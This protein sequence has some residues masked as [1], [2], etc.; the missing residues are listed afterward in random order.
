MRL[1][2]FHPNFAEVGGAEILALKHAELLR[3]GGVEV[4]FVTF[5]VKGA[6]WEEALRPWTVRVVPKRDWRD[7]L[8]GW[9]R[10][11]K[12]EHRGRR[13]LPFLQGFDWILGTNH[14]CCTM[15]GQLPVSGGKVWYCNEPPRRLFPRE[16]L[17]YGTAAL[18]RLGPV[19]P[20]LEA[21]RRELREAERPFSPYR[22]VRKANLAAIP[23]LDSALFNSAY[24]M[25]N[26]RA[27]YGPLAG[28][29]LYPVIDFPAPVPPRQGLDR[30]ALRILVQARLTPFKNIETVVDG[31]KAFRLRHPGAELHI[32]GSGPS[33]AALQA[34][35][36]DGTHFHGFLSR[37]EVDQLRQRCGVFA[38]LPLDEPFGMVYPEAAAQGLL[39]VGPDHGGP[40]EI[41]RDGALGW[42][43]AALDPAAF[44]GALEAICASSDADLEQRRAEA[45]LSCRDRFSPEALGPQLLRRFS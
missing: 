32:L 21:L 44:T 9:T 37:E 22:G 16:T 31:F 27:A 12:L 11:G 23:R 3:A 2:Y 45:D 1:A 36:G 24:S 33:K 40:S 34:R 41:L 13:A 4:E 5:A 39:L 8:G 17:P 43:C 18:E 38:L 28:E 42:T 35:A 7:L 19:T 29:V 30:D 10:L 6:Y 15:L 20:A 25:A 14:P 26:A